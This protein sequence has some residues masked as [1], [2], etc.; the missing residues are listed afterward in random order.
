M[1]FS[2][3][4]AESA[5]K[6]VET[7]RAEVAPNMQKLAIILHSSLSRP[8]TTMLRWGQIAIKP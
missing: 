5:R 8:N 7:V 6:T 1:S 2:C 3:F 4:L